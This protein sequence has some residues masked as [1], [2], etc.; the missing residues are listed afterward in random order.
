MKVIPAL[1]NFYRST[2]TGWRLNLIE[3]SSFSE[4]NL[5]F[6]KVLKLMKH[7]F[8]LWWSSF[9]TRIPRGSAGNIRTTGSNSFL[10]YYLNYN[11]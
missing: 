6:S 11:S 3:P 5:S 8:P 1:F 4:K 7:C 10:L 9:I 2:A